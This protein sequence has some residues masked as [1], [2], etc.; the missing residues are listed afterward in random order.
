MEKPHERILTTYFVPCAEQ[1]VV[2][3]HGRKGEPAVIKRFI[4]MAVALAIVFGGLYGF[5]RFREQAIANFF[6]GNKPPPAPVEAADAKAETMPR[7]L[8]GIGTL[9]AVHQVTVAPEVGGRVTQIF[10]QAGAVVKA[11]DPLIQLY[12]KTEQAD[13]LNYRAQAKLAEANLARSRELVGRNFTPQSTVDQN[14]AQLDEANA[15]IARVQALISQKLVRAPFDGVLG[16]RLVDVGQYLSPGSSIVTLTDLSTLYVNFT[17]PEQ[18]RS[19]I[20]V[21]QPVELTTDAFPGRVFAAKVTAIEPQVGADTRAITVQATMENPQNL[22]LPGMFANVRVVL[23]AQPNVITVPE[24]AVDYTLYGDSVF[25]IEEDGKDD[26]GKPLLKAT[27]TFVRTGDRFDNRVAIL[28]GLKPGD[29]VAASG[30]LKLTSG[31]RVVVGS[32]NAL[33]TPSVVPR[34]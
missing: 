13:L 1:I 7:R 22:L 11:G 32:T 26:S 28:T 29:R 16:I 31:A 4:L 5:N 12:D 15:N 20:A 2:V 27:R 6:A 21:A 23:S 24:T 17:L 3:L 34:N 8:P 14:Q 25:L 30:Q 33:A 9:A 10:F 18:T 19:Q